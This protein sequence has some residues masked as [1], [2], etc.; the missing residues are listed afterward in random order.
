LR[1]GISEGLWIRTCYDKDLEQAHER[2]WYDNVL[3]WNALGVDSLV[4]DDRELVQD[5]WT[6]ILDIFPERVTN[7]CERW[8]AEFPA[9]VLG[10]MEDGDEESDD[11]EEERSSERGIYAELRRDEFQQEMC[12]RYADYHTACT[13][14]YVFIEDKLAQIGEG[15]LHAYLDGC[16]NVVR[17]LREEPAS[18][19]NFDGAWL[20]GCWD[21]GPGFVKAEVG[22][23]YLPGGVRGPPYGGTAP[24][25]LQ[26]SVQDS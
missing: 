14:T 9:E 11:N 19:D 25:W 1:A 5:P 13:V 7:S 22:P 12:R 10:E 23:A 8:D 2:V 16:G 17:Q 26:L 20:D 6:S 18:L 21:E 15:L 24:Y 4:L 3:K